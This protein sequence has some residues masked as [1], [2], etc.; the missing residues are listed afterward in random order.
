VNR[1]TIMARAAVKGINHSQD[2]SPIYS[3]TE[4]TDARLRVGSSSIHV[5]SFGM[6]EPH[7]LSSPQELAGGARSLHEQWL[8]IKE[9]RSKL[10]FELHLQLNEWFYWLAKVWFQL[11]G[12]SVEDE[13]LD[14][15]F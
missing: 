15:E 4:L 8:T 13:L 2:T 9:L 11:F 14:K 10:S 1:F 3:P 12:V 7:A 6:R 5:P